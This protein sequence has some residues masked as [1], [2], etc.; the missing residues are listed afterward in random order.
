VSRRGEEKQ[1]GSTEES[2]G[3][4]GQALGAGGRS[5]MVEGTMWSAGACVKRQVDV[6]CFSKSA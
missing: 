2:G 3:G 5:T 4:D 6:I 1:R